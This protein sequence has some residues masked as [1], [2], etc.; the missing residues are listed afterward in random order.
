MLNQLPKELLME[1]VNNGL[2]L[3]VIGMGTVFLFLTLL[4]FT[5]KFMSSIITRYFPEKA[6][7]A[8]VRKASPASTGKAEGNEI[9]AAIAAAVARSRR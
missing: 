3:L 9:A 7:P 8:P 4:V 1:Q 6:S 5:T 2:I